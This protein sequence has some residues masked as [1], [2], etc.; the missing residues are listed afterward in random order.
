[1]KEDMISN[2]ARH[3]QTDSPTWMS[4]VLG[5]PSG[6]KGQVFLKIYFPAFS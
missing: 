1:M 5:L 2:P 4:P 6:L 3:L